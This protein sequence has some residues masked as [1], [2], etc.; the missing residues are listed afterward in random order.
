M[1]G[2]TN[3]SHP[4]VTFVYSRSKCW[5]RDLIHTESVQVEGSLIRFAFKLPRNLLK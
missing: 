5:R 2:R 1:V 4:K 3:K